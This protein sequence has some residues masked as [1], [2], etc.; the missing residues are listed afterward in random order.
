MHS[1]IIFGTQNLDFPIEKPS[2]ICTGGFKVWDLRTLEFQDGGH[3][4]G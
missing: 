1:E 2:K 4:K 3:A